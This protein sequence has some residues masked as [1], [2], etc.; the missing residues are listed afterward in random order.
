ML[1]TFRDLPEQ[2]ASTE[3]DICVNGQ[4]AQNHTAASATRGERSPL[5][6]LKARVQKLTPLTM[7]LHDQQESQFQNQFQNIG[8][9][10][11]S[12][13]NKIHSAAMASAPPPA[14]IVDLP[15]W[16]RSAYESS[17]LQ[18]PTFNYYRSGS[19]SAV[20][21]NKTQSAAPT[22][23]ISQADFSLQYPP[24]A[25]PTNSYQP[26]YTAAHGQIQ[27][28]LQSQQQQPSNMYF[29]SPDT[30]QSAYPDIT[31]NFDMNH[32]QLGRS[33]STD[34][35]QFQPAI[36]PSTA[37]AAPLSQWAPMLVTAPRST[38]AW[39]SSSY[40]P[41]PL[42]R[43][44]VSY[45]PTMSLIPSPNPIK[46]LIDM[47]AS[48][49]S[50]M[51]QC[52]IQKPTSLPFVQPGVPVTHT[53]TPTV[54][55]TTTALKTADQEA[56]AMMI[57]I[58]ERT[59]NPYIRHR[60]ALAS[61]DSS[62]YADLEY[63]EPVVQELSSDAS[64][65]S[66]DTN[67]NPYISK[68][69]ISTPV[70][71]SIY[72]G[73]STV[74]GNGTSGG[75]YGTDGSLARPRK[76][77]KISFSETS[78][79]IMSS[80]P[81]FYGFSSESSRSTNA[82]E[83]NTTIISSLRIAGRRVDKLPC[84]DRK[85]LN[86]WALYHAV[87]ELGGFKVVT[88]Q[89]KWKKVADL[90]KLR[91][92]LTSSSFT[93]RTY[94]EYFLGAYEQ[95]TNDL[96]SI[97]ESFLGESD[98][99]RK[100]SNMESTP[101]HSL[102]QSFQQPSSSM[103]LQ[104]KLKSEPHYKPQPQSQ[105]QPQPQLNS[106]SSDT[107]VLLDPSPRCDSTVYPEFASLN[108]LKHSGSSIFS[109][110]SSTSSDTPS[111]ETRTLQTPT[112]LSQ[113]L[114]QFVSNHFQGHIPSELSMAAQPGSDMGC[115]APVCALTGLGTT[116]PTSEISADLLGGS[117]PLQKQL[118]S[119]FGF[120]DLLS[121]PDW[122]CGDLKDFNMPNSTSHADMFDQDGTLRAALMGG[123]SSHPNSRNSTPGD[124]GPFQFSGGRST[125]EPFIRAFGDHSAGMTKFP[126]PAN[127]NYNPL[128]DLL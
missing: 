13:N 127:S 77:R 79:S 2:N 47:S 18:I 68:G 125:P 63:C 40:N 81:D 54:A 9:Q 59:Q 76:S 17:H 44:P 67:F 83:F 94:Y 61:S 103:S 14:T 87:L 65:M 73:D 128:F 104:S 1:A 115:T 95:Q 21:T 101:H 71:S 60:S 39:L 15:E 93:L 108:A 32:L 7:P 5:F 116:E 16:Q 107:K 98:G 106:Q 12:I 24:S 45:V 89:R 126:A 112:M 25:Y 78:D 114:P 37:T 84:V 58:R 105:P 36:H 56:M 10:H 8:S 52:T 64:S 99:R 49:A 119:A 29:R 86:F 110:Y 109:S 62:Q 69:P 53:K 27:P 30:I 90:L 23:F 26:R 97:E 117:S 118:F 102:S 122:S 88:I 80:D 41:T 100:R 70:I 123:I 113:R 91:K 31:G 4:T 22:M 51:M 3:A 35:T 48:S 20:D 120:E 96:P 74:I 111:T 57:G 92:S 82:V 6:K 55:T 11:N 19:M 72:P 43:G 121:G 38:A 75:E 124:T 66:L 50:K 28:Q 46:S 42:P 34:L 85:T 33:V